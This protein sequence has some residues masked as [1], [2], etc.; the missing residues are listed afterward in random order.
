M[1]V[2]QLA[3]FAD[4]GVLALR[5]AV[6]IIF[7]VHGWPKLTQ[8]RTMGAGMAQMSGMS[9]T[10]MT[11]WMALQGAVEVGGGILLILGIATQLVALA[12]VV[13]MVGA[14]GLKM[15]MM[16]VGF[17]AQQATGWEFDFILLAASLLLLLTGPGAV[18][19]MPSS[20][21]TI[22]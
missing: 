5:V 21:V 22:G 10:V 8:A 20:G 14:I 2:P 1:L 17:T 6:G 4:W 16:K 11:G 19:I 18:A 13:I 7:I 15:T 9:P 12:F 3:D